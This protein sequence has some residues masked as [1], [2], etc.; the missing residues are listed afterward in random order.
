[1]SKR[2]S[3]HIGL[4]HVDP[5]QYGGW[6]GELA[7][8]IND[9]NDMQR[10]AEDR[11]FATEMLID[12]EATIDAVKEKLNEY[13]GE[14]EAGDF[15]F[16]SYSGHGGQVPDQNGDEIDGYDETW[17]LYDTEL[18]DDSLYGALCTFKK[19]VRIFIMSD[20]CHSETVTRRGPGSDR[21]GNREAK[22]AFVDTQSGPRSKRAP[23]EYTTAEYEKNK[24]KYEAQQSWWTPKQMPK[25]SPAKVVLISGCK[26]EQTSM[27]GNGNGAFTEAFLKV[28]NKHGKD[29]RKAY[30]DL[31]LEVLA[32]IVN[33]DQEPQ[34]FSYGVEVDTMRAQMP[35][36]DE[37]AQVPA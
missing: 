1:M 8:C 5:D 4:N 16:V 20:S 19:G 12:G 10:I 6:D 14:L 23:L 11:G 37:D 22:R 30:R 33:S 17:C 29:Y 18:V 13:A 2:K 27:D 36:S 24:A 34:I 28:W 9:A 25:D 32:A 7:G 15:L 21:I 31:Q 26:D 3:L 35:F